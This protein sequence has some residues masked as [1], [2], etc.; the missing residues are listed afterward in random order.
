ALSNQTLTVNFTP[1]VAG[2]RSAILTI[3]NDDADE[4]TYVI[5]LN[6]IGGNY[7]SEPTGAPT[8]LSFTSVKSYRF[9]LNWNAA[10]PTPDGYIV[11]RRDD[12]AVT[13]IHADG[14]DYTEG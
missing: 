2:T 10:T 12:A 7:V 1:S 6:G 13:D 8:N 9:K 14:M 11:L 5:N 4:G 3:N